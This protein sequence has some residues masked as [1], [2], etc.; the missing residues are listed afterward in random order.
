MVARQG[1]G[2][3]TNTIVQVTATSSGAVVDSTFGGY[4]KAKMS[5]DGVEKASTCINYHATAQ[6]VQ[7]VINAMD[8]DDNGDG[9]ANTGDDNNHIKVTRRGDGSVTSGYGYIY[10]QR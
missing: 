4:L 9:T 6:E 5:L 7:D 8:F 1:T 3:S 2:N 10:D